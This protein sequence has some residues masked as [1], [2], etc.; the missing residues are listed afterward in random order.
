VPIY[1]DGHTS[2]L[3]QVASH[4]H[5]TL[6]LGLL[7]KEFKKRV[8]TPVRVVIGEPISREDIEARSKDARLMM[9]FL[10]E[11]TYKLSPHPFKSLDIGFEFEE[12]Y[13]N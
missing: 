2:R 13:K 6:R 3:F 12:R 9:E 11:S 1:F 10:R 8:D 7:I 4:L 5:N